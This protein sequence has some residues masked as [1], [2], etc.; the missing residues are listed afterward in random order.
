M[1]DIDYI[2]AH[3]KRP[4]TNYVA[5]HIDRIERR[6]GGNQELILDSKWRIA[7]HTELVDDLAFDG[8]LTPPQVATVDLYIEQFKLTAEGQQAIAFYRLMVKAPQESNL[9]TL[10]AIALEGDA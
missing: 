2:A 5:D 8:T 4:T 1:A 9:E 6:H 3:L 7:N 10:F